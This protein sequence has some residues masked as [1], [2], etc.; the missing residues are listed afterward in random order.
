MLAHCVD[1]S[2][3]F[4]TTCNATERNGERG[5]LA[6]Y[7]PLSLLQLAA[8]LSRKWARITQGFTQGVDLEKAVTLSLAAH[9]GDLPC[10]N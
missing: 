5:L 2:P 1:H 10:T 4:H 3:G 6:A 9:A 8:A 7:G